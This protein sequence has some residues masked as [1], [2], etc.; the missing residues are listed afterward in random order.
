[1]ILA[2]DAPRRGIGDNS[3]KAIQPEQQGRLRWNEFEL[4]PFAHQHSSGTASRFSLLCHWS[5]V[6]LSRVVPT[7]C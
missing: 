5:A 1:M 3:A 2:R 6:A 4:D 7:K